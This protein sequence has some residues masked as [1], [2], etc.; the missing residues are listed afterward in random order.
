MTVTGLVT[1]NEG[2]DHMLTDSQERV[3]GSRVDWILIILDWI[4]W[5]QKFPRRNKDN[6]SQT[7]REKVQR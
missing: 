7:D 6:L 4:L 5:S 3:V 1:F 2:L